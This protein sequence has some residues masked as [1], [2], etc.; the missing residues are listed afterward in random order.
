[1]TKAQRYMAA[2][3]VLG[4]T[5][6]LTICEFIPESQLWLAEN[7]EKF[8]IAYDSHR[9]TGRLWSA[10]VNGTDEFTGPDLVSVLVDAVL[11]VAERKPK[12]HD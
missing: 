5:C 7:T 11:K 8:E 1:M 12:S 9:T 2:C 3:K 6:R 10:I 4:Y